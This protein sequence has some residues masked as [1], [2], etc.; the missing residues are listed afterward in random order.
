MQEVEITSDLAVTVVYKSD[1]GSVRGRAENC[2]AGGVLLVPSDPARR[3]VFSRSAPCDSSGL[4]EVR[5]V[6][7][8]DYLAL[9]FAGNG[10][11]SELDEA[12][13]QPSR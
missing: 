3:R 9:A 5:A 4:Y 12:L 13:P 6:R 7:P 8:G 2:A 10:P 1:G 11:V